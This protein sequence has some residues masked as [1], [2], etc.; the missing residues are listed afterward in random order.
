MAENILKGIYPVLTIPFTEKREVDYE[1]LK[2]LINFLYDRG[3]DGV[4]MFGLN[5]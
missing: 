2:N 4:T 5:S 1:S 3:V